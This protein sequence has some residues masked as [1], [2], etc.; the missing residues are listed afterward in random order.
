MI[1]TIHI[2]GAEW[3][4]SKNGN[5]Y[6][7]SKVYVDGERVLSCP[8]EYGYGDHYIEIAAQA[9]HAKG[10]INRGERHSSGAWEPLWRV[11]NNQGI[12]LTYEREVTTKRRV[13]AI[14]KGGT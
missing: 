6:Q 4:D 13:E 7:S 8:L 10:I 2:H 5:T 1:K 12:K 14:G 3:F 11:C 9:L